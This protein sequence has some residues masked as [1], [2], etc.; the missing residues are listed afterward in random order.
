MLPESGHVIIQESRLGRESNHDILPTHWIANKRTPEGSPQLV[1][2]KTRQVSD[3]KTYFS[4]RPRAL[5]KDYYYIFLLVG[6]ED[7]D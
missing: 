7:T 3:L 4:Y 5:D 2:K 1:L 6:Q